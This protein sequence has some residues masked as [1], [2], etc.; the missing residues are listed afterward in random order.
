MFKKLII[1]A[2][3]LILA[4]FTYKE[5]QGEGIIVDE[6]T[7]RGGII[8]TSITEYL[9]DWKE[10]AKDIFT[11]RKEIVEEELDSEKEKLIERLKEKGRDIW[12]SIGDFIFRRE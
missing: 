6:V 2:I 10:R 5:I 9:D 12:S 1:F 11:E 3:L 8:Y 7:N 4:F